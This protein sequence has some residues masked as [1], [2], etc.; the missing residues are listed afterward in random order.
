[1]HRFTEPTPVHSSV[2]LVLVFIE[3]WEIECCGTPPVVG[4]DTSWMLTF[5][6]TDSEPNCGLPRGAR[7]DRDAKIVS[8]GRMN[9][10]WPNLD[11]T[12]TLDVRGYFL[13]TRHG[14]ITP[15]GVGFTTGHVLDLQV[16]SHEYRLSE[17]MWQTVV[18]TR[19]L[20]RVARSPKWFTSDLEGTGRCETRVWMHL[21]VP[22]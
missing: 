16:E 22:R 12:S 8:S 20:R 15:E 14:G 5:V 6:E 4:G 18:G 11:D 9:A 2:D 19:T 3:G 10:Y 21:A 1:M 7:W 17:K 13:A